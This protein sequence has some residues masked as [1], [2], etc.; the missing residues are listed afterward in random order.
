MTRTSRFLAGAACAAALFIPACAS[1][2]GPG[3][4][5]PDRSAVVVYDGENYSG[6]AL[7][8]NGPAA[9]LVDLRLNDAISS[10]RINSGAWE[11]CEDSDF[12]GRCEVLTASTPS[13]RGLRLNDNISSLRPVGGFGALPGQGFASLTLYSDT[14]LRGDALTVNRD[15]PSLSRA[16]FNDRARSVDIRAGIWEL[17]VDGDYR[18][19]CVTLDRPTSDL[20]DAGL[21]GNVSSV[22]LLPENRYRTGY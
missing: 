17:C 11:V 16:G 12:R 4:G 21:S 5:S 1:G 13:L 15:E 6:T 2:Y 22:R 10:I 20:R 19:R 18:G 3:Y 14:G 7:P 8:L 9:N